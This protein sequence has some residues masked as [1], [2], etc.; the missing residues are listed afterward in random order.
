MQTSHVLLTHL[1]LYISSLN[2]VNIMSSPTC[3]CTCLY[4]LF[5]YVKHFGTVKY[6]VCKLETK[7]QKTENK[8]MPNRK[9]GL[10]V[11]L[12]L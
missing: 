3:H 10:F 6:C 11:L 7:N 5:C 4:I 12:S 2:V 8:E 9:M 1:L